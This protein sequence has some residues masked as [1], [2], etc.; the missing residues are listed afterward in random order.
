[1]TLPL[2]AIFIGRPSLLVNVVSRLM[3]KLRQMVAIKS[4]ELYVGPSTAVPS[5]FVA[6]MATPG[7]MP[8]PPT[9]TLQ[10]RAQWSRPASPLI[11]GVRPNSPIQ[12]TAVSCSIP[13][14]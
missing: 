10:L 14:W 13:R 8:A 3:P 1:M 9:T 6:P 11:R 12:I 7:F 2:L 4:S 5:S